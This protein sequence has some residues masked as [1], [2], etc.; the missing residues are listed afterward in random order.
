[1]RRLAPCTNRDHCRRPSS[2][3][4]RGACSAPGAGPRSAC[5]PPRRR[6]R[7]AA[8]RADGTAARSGPEIDTAATTRPDGPRTGADTEATPVSRSPTLCAQPR[9]RTPDS[10]VA[11]NLRALQA[12]VQ[13]VRLLP[14]EQHLRGRAGVHRQRW[15][16]PGSSRAGRPDARPR[17]R[18]CAGRPGGGTAGRSRRCGRAGAP[19]TGPAAASSRSSPAADA[20]SASRGPSTNRPCMSRATSRWCSRAT[21][22]RCAV[23]RASPVAPTSC[24]EGGRAGLERAQNGGGLVEDADSA[25]VVHA[26]DTAVSL[27]ETQV[28]ARRLWATLRRTGTSRRFDTWRARWPRRSGTRTSCA[29][30]RVSPT[31]STSTCTCVH[32]VTSPQA[33]DGLRLAG[34]TVRRTDLTLATEDH[35]V[36]TDIDRP[37][38]RPGQPHPGRDAA[39]QLRG[40]R[41]PA[42]P[43]GRRRAGHRPRRRARSSA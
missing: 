20:S 8:G 5:S 22:S 30:P 43:A 42:A 31:C 34:R 36:P 28:P 9:R 37:D 7:R 17:R 40:V 12:A 16:R 32:E 19:S 41:R 35:N 15:R 39:P 24:G 10:A 18:R 27:P 14:G 3:L 23:G 29:G 2:R 33:F 11:V 4:R 38:R 1:M 6:P 25:R 26:L 21:A 13:P